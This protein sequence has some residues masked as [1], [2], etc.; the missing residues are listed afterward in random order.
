MKPPKIAM[1]GAG[2]LVFCKTLSADILA[3]PALQDTEIRLMGPTQSKLDKME[4]FL[5]SYF[6]TL[7]VR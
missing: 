2:S 7:E 1:I 4:T 3:T 6:K 5:K